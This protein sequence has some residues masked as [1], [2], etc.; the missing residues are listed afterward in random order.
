M[1]TEEYDYMK[2][3][4]DINGFDIKSH[5]D[6]AEKLILCLRSWFSETVDLRNLNSAD[7]IYSDFIVFNK[8]LFIKKMSKYYP[9][10]NT[11]DA[12][13]FAKTEIEQLTIPEFID[14]VTTR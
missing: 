3:I 11:S 1:E 10:H 7:K 13:N 6:D 4:S 9:E 8:N 5:D 2:A 12:E 14:E